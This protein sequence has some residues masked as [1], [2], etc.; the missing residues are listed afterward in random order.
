M[1]KLL[2]AAIGVLFFTTANAQEVNVGLDFYNRYVFRGVD[3]GDGPSLQPTIEF[4]SGGFTIGAWGAFGTGNGILTNFNEADLY[5]S[6]DFDFGLS[7]GATSYYYPGSSWFELDKGVSSH[8]LEL[9]LGYEVSGLS[10]SANYIVNDSSDGAGSEGGDMYFEIGYSGG[11]FDVFFGA[12][13]GWHTTN[14]NLQV[15]NVGIGTSKEIKITDTFSIPMS[16]SLI[17]NPN[18]EQFYIVVGVSF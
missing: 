6:Y 9:N 18:T 4:T 3:F 16:G 10:L 14:G 5:A 7:L 2:I 13:D 15:V 17:L 1:K 8:A 11:I 12:G